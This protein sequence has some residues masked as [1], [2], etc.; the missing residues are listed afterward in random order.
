MCCCQA[1]WNSSSCRLVLAMPHAVFRHRERN[2]FLK[3]ETADQS[4]KA[5]VCW[6]FWMCKRN[7]IVGDIVPATDMSTIISV[8]YLLALK[9]QWKVRQICLIFSIVKRIWSTG[10]HRDQNL[11]CLSTSSRLFEAVKR[12]GRQLGYNSVLRQCWGSVTSHFT[13]LAGGSSFS[14]ARRSP[15]EAQPTN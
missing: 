13:L 5:S 1:S 15:S 4:C 9:W 12:S 6:N 2:A 8:M 10:P 11:V 3:A 7:D 14:D